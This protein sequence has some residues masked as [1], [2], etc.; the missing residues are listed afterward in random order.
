MLCERCLNKLT[1]RFRKFEIN[2]YKGLAI[3]DYDD[4]IKSLLYQ[5]KGCY[6]YELKDVFF[7]RYFKELS[8]YYKGYIVVPAPSYHIDD[9]NRGFNHVEEIY[10]SFN[11]KIIDCVKK[12]SPHKQA[13]LKKK[14]R[15]EIEHHLIIE[16]PEQL[17]G[18]KVLIVDDVM[19]TG[20]T[21]KAMIDLIKKGEPKKIKIVVMSKRV[22]THV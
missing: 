19:T 10:K 22:V 21:L 18:E 3:Y 13:G 8:I 2:G 16:N 6:D 4:E 9:D 12:I 17:R 11:L 1:P 5:F 7:Y 15:L 14:Q 20:S